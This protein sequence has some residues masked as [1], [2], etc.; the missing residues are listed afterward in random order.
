MA[1]PPVVEWKHVGGWRTSGALPVG[2]PLG[3]R[4][5]KLRCPCSWESTAKPRT[6]KAPQSAG[7][8]GDTKFSVQT[9][10][11]MGHIS[12]VWFMAEP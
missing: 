7:P 1:L 9:G 4:K 12:A 11:D 5:E 2:R 10:M 6:A 8:E 3:E